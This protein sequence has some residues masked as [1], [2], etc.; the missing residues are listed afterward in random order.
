[1]NKQA[2]INRKTVKKS[3]KNNSMMIIFSG[4]KLKSSADGEYPFVVNR[5]FY[6]LTQINEPNLVLTM[7]KNSEVLFIEE[8]DEL[9]EKWIG[10]KISKQ[11]SFKKSNI[12]DVRYLADFKEEF[13]NNYENIYLD[14]EKDQFNNYPTPALKFKEDFKLHVL[15]A[16]PIITKSRATK[17]LTEVEKISEALIITDEGLKNIMRSLKANKKES[18]FEAHFDFVLKSKNVIPAF[19]TIAA[20]G[21][22]ATTL[23]YVTNDNI[24]KDGDLILFDLGATSD[25]Y[26]ADIS[27]TYPVNGKFTKRQKELY[28]MVLD[29]NEMVID[30]IKPGITMK[31]LN[32][33]VI[34]LYEKEL[35]RLKVIK[36]VE[37][38]KN[39]YY[40]GVSHS[41]GLD[42]HDVGLDRS[43]P[44]IKGNVIT[45]EPGIYIKEE[46]IGIRIE[47]NIL[48]TKEGSLNLSKHIIKSIEDIEEFM[49][50]VKEK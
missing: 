14:L 50:D 12:E 8:S 40:H 28:K 18:Y 33:I 41:L 43:Q 30:A 25:L 11:E 31:E 5:N 24:A 45:V 42:T 9:F 20:S 16:Y 39:Y 26:C 15:D 1:M 37:E 17:S 46:N 35:L 47:D 29:A 27:R 2:S 49:S 44:L 22:N 21:A 13:F 23:H 48:V 32:D 10:K 38:V 36:N 4:N 7:T 6:H 19:D 3:M 34:K